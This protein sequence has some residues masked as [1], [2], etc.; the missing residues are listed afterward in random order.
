LVNR[1]QERIVLIRIKST[2][3][4]RNRSQI[5]QILISQKVLNSLFQRFRINTMYKL[6]KNDLAVQLRFKIP[7]NILLNICQESTSFFTGN[8]N[9]PRPLGNILN[10]FR[11]IFSVNLSWFNHGFKV[12]VKIF[13]R[14]WRQLSLNLVEILGLFGNGPIYF[15]F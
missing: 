5:I 13:S 3:I 4:H 8:E 2:S 6:W 9:I 10:R 7:K 14:L 1:L 15:R 12:K 11:K